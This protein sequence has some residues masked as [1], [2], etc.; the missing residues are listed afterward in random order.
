MSPIR[1]L[2]MYHGSFGLPH[3]AHTCTCTLCVLQAKQSF[4]CGHPN[5]VKVQSFVWQSQYRDCYTGTSLIHVKQYSAR[6]CQLI[7]QV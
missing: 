3:H 2:H 5:Y 1:T 7:L 6:E 4:P